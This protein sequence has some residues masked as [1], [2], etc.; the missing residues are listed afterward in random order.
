MH[1]PTLRIGN[2]P[3]HLRKRARRLSAESRLVKSADR[4]FF[5]LF[6]LSFFLSLSF[7]D[8]AIVATPPQ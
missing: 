8:L 6:F 5:F 1:P 2:P 4:Y 3:K 7:F